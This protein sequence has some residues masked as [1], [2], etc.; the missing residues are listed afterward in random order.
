MD[1]VLITGASS[2]IGLALAK[3]LWKSEYKVVATLR[4]QSFKKIQDQAFYETER[5]LIRPLD[6]NS[7]TEQEKLI[8]EIKRKWGSIDIL[9]N[10][11]GIS[12]RSVVEHMGSDDELNQLSTNYLAPMNLIKLV[13]PGMREKKR[14]R[15]INV[16]SVGGMMAMPTMASYSASKFALEG[17][18]ESLW[19]EMRPWNIHVSLIAPGFINSDSFKNVYKTDLY[20]KSEKTRANPYSAYYHHMGK[21]IQRIMTLS[22]SDAGDVAEV[23]VKTMRKK[24]PPLR[25]YA[26]IDALLFFYLRRILPRGFYH[27][28]LYTFLPGIRE[29]GKTNERKTLQ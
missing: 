23:I 20:K 29:W 13:L 6:I 21:F 10:N 19:Y 26:T 16:S 3:K 22:P 11:A 24:N 14:G 5:F 2:G 1:I 18:S 12:Y 28:L 4:R 25:V 27:K 9:V 15:I 7:F 17:A 8:R